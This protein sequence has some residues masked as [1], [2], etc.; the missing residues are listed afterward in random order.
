MTPVSSG[1][2]VVEITA[3]GDASVL[4]LVQREV[5]TCGPGQILIEVVA[6]GVNR[7]DINQRRRGPDCVHSPIPGLEVSGRVAAIGTGV[8]DYL[9]GEAVCALVNGGGYGEYALAEVAQA[10]PAP[11]TIP[12]S[13]AA[14][15]PEGLFTIWYNFFEVA[16]LKPGERV[17]IHGGTSGVGTLALQ[18]L[19]TLGH[20]VYTTCGSDSKCELARS[21]G[22]TA[23]F[24]YRAG[25]FDDAVLN[26][27]AHQGV[28]VIL[29]MA[30]PIYARQN[31]RALARKGRIVHLSPGDGAEMSFPLR[32]M[33]RKEANVTGTLLRPL[34][35]EEK[36]AIGQR[37]RNDVWS[38]I[39]H[40]VV[41]IIAARFPLERVQDAHRELESGALAG[42][43]LLDVSNNPSH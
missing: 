21:L 31:L 17:L 1:Q 34:P 16:R 35:D 36:A 13:D 23:A 33:M 37:I 32:E 24:N 28:N 18:L 7:H 43:V 39:G 15:L 22:A 25:N 9:V 27:T 29:D 40:E 41:P 19:S 14:A 8:T 2:R 11:P 42:K 3:P 38:K 12:L 5:P 20:E 10:F 30:G 26:A 6:A 4:E